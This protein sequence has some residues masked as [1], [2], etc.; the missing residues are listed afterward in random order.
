MVIIQTLL[1]IFML[2][3]DM[4]DGWLKSLSELIWIYLLSGFMLAKYT[5][6]LMVLKWKND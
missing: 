1:I 5:R 3:N 6:A 4:T 2:E